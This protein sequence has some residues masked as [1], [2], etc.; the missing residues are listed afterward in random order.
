MRGLQ[1][2]VLLYGMPCGN[3]LRVVRTNGKFSDSLDI[4]ESTSFVFKRSIHWI[5][6]TYN[7]FSRFNE[8]FIAVLVSK[9][10]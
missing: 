10:I 6:E 8:P 5:F 7:I 9:K 1:E 2:V 3:A 4:D